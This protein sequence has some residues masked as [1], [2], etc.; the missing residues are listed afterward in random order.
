MFFWFREGNLHCKCHSSW[1]LR[2]VQ[3]NKYMDTSVQDRATIISYNQN[4]SAHYKGKPTKFLLT[5]Q[6]FGEVIGELWGT[7]V[8]LVR[9]DPLNRYLFGWIA[10]P[11]SADMTG[12]ALLSKHFSLKCAEHNVADFNGRNLFYEL[13]Q[14]SFLPWSFIFQ[15]VMHW[16][17]QSRQ[18]IFTISYLGATSHTIISCCLLFHLV[19]HYVRVVWTI[20]YVTTL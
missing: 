9:T 11:V 2:K 7:T 15:E 5:T 17:S 4:K 20:S 8:H 6:R 12:T 19:C 1:I 16:N 18:M 13:W 14:S 10:L 3:D